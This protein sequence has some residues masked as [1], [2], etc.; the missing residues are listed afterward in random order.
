MRNLGVAILLAVVACE[1]GKKSDEEILRE[2]I[3]S[4]PVHVYVAAKVALTKSGDDARIRD[5]REKLVALFAALEGGDAA[6]AGDSARELSVTDL[7]GVGQAL[8]EL[9]A[10]G[11]DI[12]RNGTEDELDPLL[13]VLL[14]MR[15]PDDP[16]ATRIDRSTDHAVFF[17]GLW[18]LKVHPRSPTPIPDEI[19]LY[20]ASRVNTE[21]LTIPELKVLVHGL[22]AYV[23]ATNELCDLAK[24]D[25]DAFDA[26]DRPTLREAFVSFGGAP[27]EAHQDEV[28]LAAVASL[29]HGA[30]A[31]CYFGRDEPDEAREELERFVASA[32]RAGASPADL[33]LVRAYLAYSNDQLAEARTQLE[34]AK[35][36]D[37][38]TD[39]R[40]EDVDEVIEHLDREDTDFLDG[41][42]DKAFFARFA[43]E[44]A[45]READEAGVFDGLKETQ[46]YE[47]V[48]WF[49]QGTGA[50]I[51]GVGEG[52]SAAA[53]G[54]KQRASELWRKLRSD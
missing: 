51:D 35:T 9:R 2:K 23:Y 5:A 4:T 38:M 26:L 22:R 37:W 7:I 33:A 44:L 45:L 54:A 17:V 14:R 18:V 1:C 40:R 50:A 42:F 16:M 53:D 49:L 20:E 46:V 52:V 43:A 10:T 47:S 28:G 15:N 34:L 12:V 24:R 36:A 8:W 11:A 29:A 31:Y 13:P 41:Y 39:A 27:L 32:E 48:R 30:T 6:A 21:E 25:G 19:L 3:D